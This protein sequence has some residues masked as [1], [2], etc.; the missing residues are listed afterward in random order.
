MWERI[1]VGNRRMVHKVMSN[2]AVAVAAEELADEEALQIII[3]VLILVGIFIE[4]IRLS[5]E[6]FYHGT[7]WFW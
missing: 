7:V 1:A 3:P 6:V 2:P 4:I 5:L